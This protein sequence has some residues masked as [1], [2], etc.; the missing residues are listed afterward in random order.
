MKSEGKAWMKERR[1]KV[2]FSFVMFL[3][4]YFN[5]LVDGIFGSYFWVRKG[6]HNFPPPNLISN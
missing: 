3:R 6:R 5:P 1:Y 4:L 2:T